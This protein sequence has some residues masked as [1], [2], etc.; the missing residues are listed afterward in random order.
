MESYRLISYQATG[1]ARAGIIS[2]EQIFDL[3]AATGN[4]GDRTL[5]GFYADWE[6]APG[7]PRRR[8]RC[9][10]KGRRPCR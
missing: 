10:A 6:A 9:R 3:A 4:P 8:A 2:G 7:A 5:V 1:S